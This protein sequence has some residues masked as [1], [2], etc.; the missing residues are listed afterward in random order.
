MVLASL[1]EIPPKSMSI[2]FNTTFEVGSYDPRNISAASCAL[3]VP[4]RSQQPGD[5]MLKKGT[6]HIAPWH[7]RSGHSKKHCTAR[8]APPTCGPRFCKGCAGGSRGCSLL[9]A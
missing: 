7:A 4:T 9:K 3:H 2:H 8:P 1:R 5:P 6:A